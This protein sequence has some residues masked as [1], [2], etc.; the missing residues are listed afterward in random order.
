MVQTPEGHNG[1]NLLDENSVP[2]N[3]IEGS[4]PWNATPPP[5]EIITSASSEELPVFGQFLDINAL[6]PPFSGGPLL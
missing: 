1:S 5:Q 6:E 3:G 2:I 4:D